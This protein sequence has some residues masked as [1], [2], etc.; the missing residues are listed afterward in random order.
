L[1]DILQVCFGYSLSSSS[2]FAQIFTHLFSCEVFIYGEC[3]YKLSVMFS[4]LNPP[5][6]NCVA[7]KRKTLL[8]QRNTDD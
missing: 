6:F 1:I 8:R 7:E 3:C 5:L 4:T 2:D